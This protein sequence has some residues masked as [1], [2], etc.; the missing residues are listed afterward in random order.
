[1]E[2]VARSRYLRIS[3]RKLRGVID[4]VRGKNINTAFNILAVTKKRGCALAKQTLKSAVSNS[5][6]KLNV[7]GKEH[8]DIDKLYVKEIYVDQGPTQKRWLPRS[9]GRAT[10]ILKRSCHLTVKL[11]IKNTKAKK[12]INQRSI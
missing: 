2:F 6:R 1:M 3:P 7:E 5:E 11:G 4:L 9:M 10:K 12:Q 8:A